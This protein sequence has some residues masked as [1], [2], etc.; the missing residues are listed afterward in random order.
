MEIVSL[1]LSAHT[2]SDTP[3]R[4]ERRRERRGG[5]RRRKEDTAHDGDSNHAGPS[6]AFLTQVASQMQPER[7]YTINGYAPRAWRC[8]V[9][10]DERA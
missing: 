9:I 1:A 3:D 10:A 6:M 7:T 8:G 4:Q 2:R 5:S